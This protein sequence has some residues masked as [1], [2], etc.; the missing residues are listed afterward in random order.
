MT[1]IFFEKNKTYEES[2]P[3]AVAKALFEKEGLA[4]L[5]NANP[6]LQILEVVGYD[7]VDIPDSIGTLDKLYNFVVEGA[8]NLPESIRNCK[9]LEL[10]SLSKTTG[11]IDISPL[12]HLEN[13]IVLN[14]TSSP[15][16]VGVEE[17]NVDNILLVT[18]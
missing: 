9:N 1:E 10:L 16:L 13:L 5:I 12:K 8:N 15:N 6:D 3:S 4:A 11:K 2:H 17:L 7:G 18:A 14:L